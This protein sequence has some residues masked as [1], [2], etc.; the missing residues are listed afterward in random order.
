MNIIDENKSRKMAHRG[1][2]SEDK[3]EVDDGSGRNYSSSLKQR[4]HDV[5][6]HFDTR[7][8]ILIDSTPLLEWR[9]CSGS[10]REEGKTSR[11][12]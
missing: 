12:S 1:V 5:I 3:D 2:T 8:N 10:R 7:K 4:S 11:Y 6:A 9:E